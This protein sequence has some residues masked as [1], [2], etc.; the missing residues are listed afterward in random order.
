MD[1]GAW[2]ATVHGGIKESHILSDEIKT[3]L[4]SLHCTKE[5]RRISAHDLCGETKGNFYF[6]LVRYI[7]IYIHT[8]IYSPGMNNILIRKESL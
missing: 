4:K 1:R 7:Y 8:H 3:S 6:H 5:S 2:Q